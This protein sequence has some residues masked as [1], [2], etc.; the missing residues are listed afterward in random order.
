MKTINILCFGDSNTWGYDPATAT[1]YAREIRWPGVLQN[2]LGSGYHIVEEGLCGR[3]TVWDD[4]VE[5]D[6]SGA[7]HLLPLLHSHAPLDLVIIALGTNDL[8]D[9]FGVGA[10]DIAQGL[11]RLVDIVRRSETGFTGPAPEVLVVCPPPLGDMSQGPFEI[12]AGGKAKSEAL[13]AAVQKHCA[14][15][16]VRCVNAAEWIEVSPADGLHFS[17]A[18]HR[19]LGEALAQRI[20]RAWCT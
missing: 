15:I 7:R 12:F 2:A 13:W 19:A 17:A 11:C 14:Q 16:K 6:K 10:D 1:R 9:R 4:P 5:G 8:K 3:T 18:A 20:D